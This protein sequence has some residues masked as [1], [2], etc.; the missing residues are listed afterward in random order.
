MQFL[1]QLNPEFLS[2]LLEEP[3]APFTLSLF[4]LTVQKMT[5]NYYRVFFFGRTAKFWLPHVLR[6]QL[7]YAKAASGLT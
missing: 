2:G 7:P 4:V 6:A 5:I 3:K 1:I